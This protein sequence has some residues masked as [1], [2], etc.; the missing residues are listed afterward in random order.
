ML[1]SCRN[2]RAFLACNSSQIPGEILTFLVRTD[3]LDRPDGSGQK[4]AKPGGAWTEG[5]TDVRALAASADKVLAHA[6]SSA[7]YGFL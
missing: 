2:I 5:G 6:E 4:F 3:V 7:V 1:R